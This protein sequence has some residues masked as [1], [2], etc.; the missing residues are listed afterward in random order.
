[1][2][3]PALVAGH[4]GFDLRERRRDFAAERADG[5]DDDDGDERSYEAVL[6]CSGAIFVLFELLQ[7]HR[8]LQAVWDIT[9]W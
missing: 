1:M 8:T 5:G 6:D 7:R 4:L 2:T 9:G 3:G